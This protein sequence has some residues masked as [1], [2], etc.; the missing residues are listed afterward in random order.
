MTLARSLDILRDL[1]AFPTV[2]PESNLEMISYLS[3]RLEAAGAR[4]ITTKD[5]SERKANLFATMGPEMT[6]GIMLSG[7]TDVVPVAD[8]DWT[9]DPFEMVER[10]GRLFGRGTCDMKG[11]VAAALALA[12]TL[13]DSDPDTTAAFRLHL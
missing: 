5:D 6:G 1:V 10:D 12:E 8:Q 7:H 2:S 11:F 4:C 3:E 13:Q 9:S